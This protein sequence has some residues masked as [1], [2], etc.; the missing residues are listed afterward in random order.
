MKKNNKLFICLNI[1]TMVFVLSSCTLNTN[2]LTEHQ[3]AWIEDIDG[4]LRSTL[5][6]AA[7]VNE[8]LSDEERNA[9]LDEL[10]DKIKTEKWDDTQIVLY[11]KELISDIQIA[12]I[13]FHPK[14]EYITDADKQSYFIG[15]EWFED[16]FYVLGTLSKYE[17]C[18]GSKLLGINGLSIEEV[19]SRYDRI[20]SNETSSYLKSLFESDTRHGFIKS[21]LEYLGIAEKDSDVITLQL[22]K[23]GIAFEQDIEVTWGDGREEVSVSSLSSLVDELPYGER[24]YME[25]NHAPFLYEID[26][27]NR[28]L[29][30]Q[31]NECYDATFK[32]EDSGYPVFSKFFDDMIV[33]MKENEEYID[34]F[35]LD[36]RNN[37]GGSELLW[38]N[39]INRHQ[40]YI[41]QFPIKV[42]IGRSTFSAG[43]DAIDMTLYRFTDVTL[44]GEETGLAVHNY[45][46]CASVIL[47]NTQSELMITQH[48]DFSHKLITRAEDVFK[49]VL[50]D[51]EVKQSFSNYLNG[52]DDVYYE[53][54]K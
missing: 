49:G 23:N 14:F 32:G 40:S 17:H 54:I 26:K 10:I 35:V 8:F 5:S 41:N 11:I 2:M 3:E 33:D 44:Y 19:L 47:P 50:P 28:A 20:Y 31:Y 9:R 4:E 53:A 51:I 29:Y 46:S 45:T 18:L 13:T 16:G 25:S 30:F 37:L 36:L 21:E 39:A 42:L 52:I 38:N 43:V 22:E 48:Q 24:L 1:I 34:Y 15:G 27:E 12:H 6:K 7:G